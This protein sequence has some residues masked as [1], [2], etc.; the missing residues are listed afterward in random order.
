MKI[1]AKKHMKIENSLINRWHKTLKAGTHPFTSCLLICS[2]KRIEW[3]FFFYLFYEK[4]FL[5]TTLLT[6]NYFKFKT[7]TKGMWIFGYWPGQYETSL[8]SIA[9]QFGLG[10]GALGRVS[11]RQLITVSTPITMTY[12]AN[13]YRSQEPSY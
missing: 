4:Y 6:K 3:K 9:N 5:I 1:T 12:R 11:T 2:C 10:W 7:Y 8:I 13:L